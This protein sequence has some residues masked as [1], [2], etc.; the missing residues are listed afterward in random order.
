[1]EPGCGRDGRLI[2]DKRVDRLLQAAKRLTDE[3]YSFNLWIVGD[4]VIADEL[5]KYVKDEKLEN[6]TFFGMQKNP[7]V[8][9]KNADV[10]VLSS[11]REG[12]ALVVPEAM[13]CGLPVIA[14]DCAG[15]AEILDNGKYGII[16]DNNDE[17]VYR[18]LKQIL[19]NPSMLDCFKNKSE[20]RASYFDAGNMVKRVIDIIE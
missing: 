3:G 2:R 19:D 15:P 6:V 4:G 16:I 5:K 13:S 7:Y 17:S 9:M 18:I 1:M 8:Y 20:G 10:F 12:F 14:T 11:Q